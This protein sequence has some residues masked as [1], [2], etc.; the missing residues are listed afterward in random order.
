M[1]TIFNKFWKLLDQGREYRAQFAASFAKQLIPLQVRASM[2]QQNMNQEKL[3]QA[4]DLTQGAI[5]RV[6]RLDNG[7]VTVNTCVRVAAG[8][9]CA[10]VPLFVPFDELHMY[11]DRVSEDRAAVPSFEQ[12][13]VARREDVLL[14]A[15][16][17]GQMRMLSV[18]TSAKNSL[19]QRAAER[20]KPIIVNSP[21]T[22]LEVRYAT[23]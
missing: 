11:L 8:L 19:E 7:N 22:Q 17:R 14:R 12:L 9:D 23:G 20:P 13:K 4:S 2:R 15:A 3:A 5:S 6:I 10:F 18:T 1:I 21:Q 16:P